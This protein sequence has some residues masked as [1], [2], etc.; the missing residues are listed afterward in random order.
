MS[1]L[2]CFYKLKENG[3]KKIFRASG[4]QKRAGVSAHILVKIDFKSKTITRDKKSLY[5]Y[6]S[7]RTL[8]ICISTQNQSIQVCKA[9]I[10]KSERIHRQQYNNIR[11]LQSSIP[12]LNG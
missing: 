10:D 6:K 8:V 11:R 5:D 7:V 9:S 12:Y 3:W 2:K 1:I 4:S